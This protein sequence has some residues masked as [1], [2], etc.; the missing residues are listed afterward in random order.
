MKAHQKCHLLVLNS[1]GFMNFIKSI[2]RS[3]KKFDKFS[4]SKAKV[5]EEY[6]VFP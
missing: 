6:E 3:F 4:V 1:K 5:E 2:L